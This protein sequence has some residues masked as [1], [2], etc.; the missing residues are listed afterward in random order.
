MKY[1]SKPF[2]T[3]RMKNEEELRQYFSFRN[4]PPEAEV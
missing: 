2:E 3:K 4:K 1:F